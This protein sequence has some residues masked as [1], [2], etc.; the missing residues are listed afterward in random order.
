VA[1]CGTSSG[2]VLWA[3][4]CNGAVARHA[5][6]AMVFKTAS[7]RNQAYMAEFH[8]CLCFFFFF[9]L[10]ES[11]LWMPPWAFGQPGPLFP[12]ATMGP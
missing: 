11:P 4:V 10:K 6:L 5:A 1:M 3:A 9:K 8:S 2:R 7:P 12:V